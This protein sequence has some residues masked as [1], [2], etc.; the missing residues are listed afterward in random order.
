MR[1]LKTFLPILLLVAAFS[2]VA[3]AQE[4]NPPACSVRI[5]LVN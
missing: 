3:V 2:I 4:A 5:L 1:Y